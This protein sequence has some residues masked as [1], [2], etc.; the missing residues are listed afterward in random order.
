LTKAEGANADADAKK[1]V[2]ATAANFILSVM[3]NLS[4]FGKE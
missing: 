3:Y 4:E 2:V 1:R